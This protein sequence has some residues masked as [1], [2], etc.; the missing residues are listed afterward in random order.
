MKLLI[1]TSFLVITFVTTSFG[2]PEMP[3]QKKYKNKKKPTQTNSRLISKN[4]VMNSPELASS[5]TTDSSALTDSTALSEG[6]E[7]VSI[8]SMNQPSQEAE[9][10]DEKERSGTQSPADS[11]YRTPKIGDSGIF[12]SINSID[13]KFPTIGEAAQRICEISHTPFSQDSKDPIKEE[14]PKD[15]AEKLANSELVCQDIVL[16]EHPSSEL[17]SVVAKEETKEEV[18]QQP[19]EQKRFIE[20][21]KQVAQDQQA[22]QKL[23]EIAQEVLE[24]YQPESESGMEFSQQEVQKDASCFAS[25]QKLCEE[26]MASKS[27]SSDSQRSG[28]ISYVIKRYQKFIFSPYYQEVTICE[29]DE[30]ADNKIIIWDFEKSV[31]DNLTNLNDLSKNH[32]LDT[33]DSY[34]IEGTNLYFGK[35]SGGSKKEINESAQN[36]SSDFGRDFPGFHSESD[37]EDSYIPEDRNL[38]AVLQRPSSQPIFTP[39]NVTLIIGAPI[40]AALI[41]QYLYSRQAA[42]QA[43]S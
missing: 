13:T 40:I 28:V 27:A 25:I 24:L 18:G 2:M 32:E 23:K 43:S 42:N 10:V 20:L 21:L 26:E 33:R 1:T 30:L 4:R 6:S 19:L 8:D 41:Y 12:N 14:S 38:R 7:K 22:D 9:T 15:L 37:N 35:K 36:S 3:G 34:Y 5:S 29:G 31:E 11:D 39:T 16:N 17:L